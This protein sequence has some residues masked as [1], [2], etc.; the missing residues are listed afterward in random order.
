MDPDANTNCFQPWCAFAVGGFWL[1]PRALKH[2]FRI[3]FL[4]P[5]PLSAFA[6]SEIAL[7]SAEFVLWTFLDND[8]FS[9]DWI[10][11]MRC[12][13]L[14]ASNDLFR[15][16]TEPA[17]TVRS[18]RFTSRPPVFASNSRAR[19]EMAGPPLL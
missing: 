5:G 19:W 13:L 4:Q 16:R 12:C 17:I 15:F 8:I 1:G 7:D 14:D 6:L 9:S 10:P 11:P 18:R 3:N 2:S